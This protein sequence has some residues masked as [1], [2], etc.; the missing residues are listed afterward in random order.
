[1]G[2][3]DAIRCSSTPVTARP[4]PSTKPQRP[5]S[6]LASKLAAAAESPAA[7]ARGY[8]EG[9]GTSHAATEMGTGA[10]NG[11]QENGRQESEPRQDGG[12]RRKRV[13][14]IAADVTAGATPL[15]AKYVSFQHRGETTG[16]LTT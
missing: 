4:R 5:P 12:R 14:D 7:A 6:T 1:M 11:E 16:D 3:P 9:A 2:N 15:K 13:E 10:R 8:L